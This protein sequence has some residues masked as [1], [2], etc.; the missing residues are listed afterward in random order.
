MPPPALANLLWLGRE[1]VLCQQA[2]VGTRMLSCLGR[3]VWRKLILGRGD[4]DEQEKGIG[5]NCILLA[6]A[7]PEELAT[8]LPPTTAQLQQ[9]FVVL[10]ARS[11][12]EVGKA[13]ML[14]V[15]RQDYVALVRTRSRVCP[16][17]A[18]IPLDEERTRQLPENGVPEQ[19][20]ACA[21]H[22]PE[23]EKVCIASVGPASRPVDVACDAHGVAK[24]NAAQDDDGED[25]SVP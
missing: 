5:G 21:Q 24:P 22:L 12:E 2:S 16:V 19:F 17:Y 9:T 15:N 7:R 20:L 10:F 14:V 23:T 3:P 4:K 6:Q 13:Q 11:I 1:H 18:D 25:L 8:S